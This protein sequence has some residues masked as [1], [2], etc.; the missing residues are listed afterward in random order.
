MTG[1]SQIPDDGLDRLMGQMDGPD[2]P[3]GLAARIVAAAT[4]LPQQDPGEPR[5]MIAP[6]PLRPLGSVAFGQRLTGLGV[7][8]LAACLAM[9][10]LPLAAPKPSAPGDGATR[11][12]EAESPRQDTPSSAEAPGQVAAAPAQT[13]SL[14]PRKASGDHLAKTAQPVRESAPEATVRD[15]AVDPPASPPV[16]QLANV[17]R[18]AEAAGPPA[19]TQGP[20]APAGLAPTGG[21]V[22]GLGVTGGNGGAASLPGRR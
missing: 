17:E 18:P 20:P 11:A 22:P 14:T 6:M 16:T 8:A 1:R 3:E 5:P 7:F 15:A 4:K 10:L 12:V 2:V 9:V 13:V 19:P 21:P